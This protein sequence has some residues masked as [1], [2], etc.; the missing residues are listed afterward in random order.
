MSGKV[1]DSPNPWWK[2][3]WAKLAVKRDSG[4]ATLKSAEQARPNPPPTA[5]PCTAATTGMDALKS[6]TASAYK[7]AAPPSGSAL[8]L[9]GENCAPAQKC[10][11][12]EQST[13]ARHE[14]SLSSRAYASA[15]SLSMG[16]SKK[17]FGARWIS[18]SATKSSPTST[19]TSPKCFILTSLVIERAG[20][21]HVQRASVEEYRSTVTTPG[22]D[23]H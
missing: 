9:C 16:T 4:A 6:R 7:P 10:L 20:N 13:M 3:S 22:V 1:T 19:L 5:A 21:G 18:T 23:S 15:R 14:G 8:P 12:S 2:P 17:L 11:P